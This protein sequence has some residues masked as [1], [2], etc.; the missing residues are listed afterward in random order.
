MV[1]RLIL[2]HERICGKILNCAEINIAL[3]D[4]THTVAPINL[5]LS[6]NVLQSAA[7]HPTK[8][9]F[10]IELDVMLG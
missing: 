5:H 9:T 10:P 8:T 1:T 4:I 6:S 7:V 2:D 3:L